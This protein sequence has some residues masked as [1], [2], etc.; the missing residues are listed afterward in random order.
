[1]ADAGQ[2]RY[3]CDNQREIAMSKTAEQVQA[4]KDDLHAWMVTN[5]LA[6]GVQWLSPDE[7]YR[8]KPPR[9][10]VPTY[11]MLVGSNE[12]SDAIWEPH[13]PIGAPAGRL[14]QQFDAI[15]KRH[16]FD[17]DFDEGNTACFLCADEVEAEHN[18]SNP[19]VDEWRRLHGAGWRLEGGDL[20]HPEDPG[21]R[22]MYNPLTEDLVLSLKEVAIVTEALK[23]RRQETGEQLKESGKE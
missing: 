5:G 20:V 15:A 13:R 3:D 11:L 18:G 12:L 22:V 23:N 14:S 2:A 21:R 17:A 16:G 6:K 8:S 1:M 4:L 10:K 9:E 7:F 19:A